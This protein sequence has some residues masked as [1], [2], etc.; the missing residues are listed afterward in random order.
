MKF[1]F[2]IIAATVLCN[3]ALASWPFL[4]IK[5]N[6]FGDN[7]EEVGLALKNNH[8][9][10]ISAPDFRKV[11]IELDTEKE[12]YRCKFPV[13]YFE[14][15]DWG[16][17][18][19]SDKT[20]IGWSTRPKTFNKEKSRECANLSNLIGILDKKSISFNRSTS[21]IS[22]VS[23]NRFLAAWNDLRF[24]IAKEDIKVLTALLSDY[25]LGLPNDATIN[26]YS[27]E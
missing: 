10:Y 11:T 5:A 20:L 1:L 26:F 14:S 12:V 2:T 16:A 6:K 15:E 25:F 3:T 19:H 22:E 13:A 23:T 7:L 21:I 9:A 27:N 17:L 18:T 8:G 24:D 4:T